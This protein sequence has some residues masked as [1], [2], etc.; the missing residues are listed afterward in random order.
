MSHW[1]LLFCFYISTKFGILVDNCS[2]LPDFAPKVVIWRL[3]FGFLHHIFCYFVLYLLLLEESEGV[4]LIFW[5]VAPIRLR[6]LRALC[7]SWLVF[8]RSDFNIP[9][10]AHCFINNLVLLKRFFWQ[11]VVLADVLLSNNLFISSLNLFSLPYAVI[12]CFAH[13]FFVTIW[14]SWA[15]ELWFISVLK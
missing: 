8:C 14:L 13:V 4:F 11:I 7:W 5:C 10:R 6:R 3:D 1:S 15:E 12:L 2:F 9:S